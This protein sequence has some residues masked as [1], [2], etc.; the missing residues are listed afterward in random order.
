MNVST[1]QGFAAVPAP[2]SSTRGPLVVV[3]Q[4]PPPRRWRTWLLF[5]VLMIS[6]GFNLMLFSA[7]HSY[8]G[9]GEGVVERFYSGELAAMDKIAL[10]QVE[11]RISPPIRS[12]I[13]KAIEQAGKD[14]HVK[15]V[16]LVVDSPGGFVADSQEIYHELRRLEQD[17]TK[18]IYVAMQRLA[19]S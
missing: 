15:G 18:P 19:A 4:G 17:H 1:Q 3:Q 11:G 7:Y 6:V 12:R 16:V 14:Q 9:T 8:L 13:L 2:E 10:V 5:L